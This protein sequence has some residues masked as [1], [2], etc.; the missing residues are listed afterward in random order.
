MHSSE[1]ELPEFLPLASSRAASPVV[2]TTARGPQEVVPEKVIV[3]LGAE[4]EVESSVDAHGLGA[5]DSFLLAY[6]L[7]D[8][9][10]DAALH[11]LLPSELGGAGEVVWV[12]M[13]G[14][15]G[16]PLARLKN[17]QAHDA[18]EGLPIYRYPA[19][20]Q[21]A[22]ATQPWSNTVERLKDAAATICDHPMNHC[23]GNLYRSEKDS[24]GAHK[25]KMLDIVEGSCIVSIS[26]GMER[27]IVLE[28]DGIKQVIQLR[29]GSLFVIGPET[30]RLWTHAIPPQ[31]HRCSPRVSLTIRHM[32]TFLQASTGNIIGKGIQHQDKNWPFWDHNFS[33]V[34][35]VQYRKRV[36]LP[37]PLHSTHKQEGS[38][39]DCFVFPC[40]S[41]VQVQEILEKLRSD[42]PEACHI[43]HAWI[44][45]GRP[46]RN[47]QP[48]QGSQA[49]RRYS[50]LRGCVADGEPV[51]TVTDSGN[52]G[53]LKPLC[54][55]DVTDCAVFV[56]RHWDGVRLGLMRLVA[57]YQA[58]TRMA[59]AQ[60]PLNTP[61]MP[62]VQG[63]LQA[64]DTTATLTAGTTPATAQKSALD[65]ELAVKEQRR[66]NKALREVAALQ[67]RHDAGE[68]LQKN[69]LQKLARRDE[70]AAQLSE[71]SHAKYPA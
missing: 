32:G 9:E 12:Q 39:F 21:H 24:I 10:A 23:V 15:D 45:R 46:S 54:E 57:A 2:S 43:P 53:L 28:R 16:R 25:D 14:S 36:P 18:G 1:S 27:P 20:N 52:E 69:Q 30:N 60:L 58:A 5:G 35:T 59:L 4:V 63:H 47:A 66:L 50:P 56:V 51:S 34:P 61:E 67:A 29:H 41:T 65:G 48:S 31:K 38:S 26:L 7:S 49:T 44:L 42:Y 22:C 8:E 55:A 33:V 37:E 68:R 40:T 70:I 17:T 71:L 62:H 3:P 64:A 19:N 6:F 13:Y 11:A